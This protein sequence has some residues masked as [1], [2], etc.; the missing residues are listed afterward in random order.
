MV[1]LVKCASYPLRESSHDATDMNLSE[2]KSEREGVEN[3]RGNGSPWKPARPLGEQ[4][5][6]FLKRLSSS[7]GSPTCPGHTHTWAEL[8]EAKRSRKSG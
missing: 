5:G 6:A 4:P 2:Q 7:P 1:Y 8:R 3:E